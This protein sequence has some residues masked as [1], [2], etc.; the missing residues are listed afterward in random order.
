MTDVFND[1]FTMI[2]AAVRTE[3]PGC[4]VTGEWVNAPAKFPTVSIVEADNYL[5]RQ[6]FD[7]S[8]EEN[9]TV[10]MYQVTVY[11]NLTSGKRFECAKI[12]G[13]IDDLL[14]VKNFFRIARSESYYDTEK[15]IYTMTA[16][17]R[18]R[19]GKREQDGS[20]NLYTI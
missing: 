18:V 10:L 1:I 6:F 19:V 14:R 4:F 13:F 17:Y 16:R 12:L 15:T 3:Y 8:L 5:D 20:F 11:S 9:V 2:A 7:N